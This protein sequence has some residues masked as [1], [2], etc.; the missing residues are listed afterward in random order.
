MAECDE[1]L[2]DL[3]AAEGAGEVEG[4]V[5]ETRRRGIGVL[6]KGWMGEED[7]LSEEGRRGVD[8]AP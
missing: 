3:E 6:E 8:C 7:S 1:Q 5:G 4:R 2:C